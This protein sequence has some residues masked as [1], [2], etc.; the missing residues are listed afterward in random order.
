MPHLTHTDSIVWPNQDTLLLINF[1]QKEFGQ[2]SSG[3]AVNKEKI[4]RG[5]M[6]CCF[7]DSLAKIR[8]RTIE[9]S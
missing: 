7:S 1:E 2:D 9:K 3:L 6:G 4:V 5:K 8:F